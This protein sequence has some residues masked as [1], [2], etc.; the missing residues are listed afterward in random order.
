MT[1]CLDWI[2]IGAIMDVEPGLIQM[3]HGL[4]A[5]VEVLPLTMVNMLQSMNSKVVMR[6]VTVALEN[7]Q[8]TD[9]FYSI[10]KI[11]YQHN[12]IICRRVDDHIQMRTLIPII[13]SIVM[14]GFPRLNI[15][16]MKVNYGVLN[17]KMWSCQK[18][19]N[20]SATNTTTTS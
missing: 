15:L 20:R 13:V 7:T 4:G 10:I 16:V 12:S 3:R 19:H 6:D 1:Y 18:D 14:K 9:G 11:L 17:L 2:K 8:I 5:N